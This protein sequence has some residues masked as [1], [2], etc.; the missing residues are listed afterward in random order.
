MLALCNIFEFNYYFVFEDQTLINFSKTNIEFIKQLYTVYDY[1][2]DGN[3]NEVHNIIETLNENTSS[4]LYSIIENKILEFDVHI[5]YQLEET[6]L[7]ITTSFFGIWISENYI[8]YYWQSEEFFGIFSGVISDIIGIIAIIPICSVLIAIRRHSKIIYGLFY[9]ASL[10]ELVIMIKLL[11]N[12]YNIYSYKGKEPDLNLKELTLN[13]WK[14]K[15]E[16]E[17]SLLEIVIIKYEKNKENN[18]AVGVKNI[19]KKEHCVEI[20]FNAISDIMIQTNYPLPIAFKK[21]ISSHSSSPPL[22]E[23]YYYEITILSN[24]NIDGT[25]IAIGFASKTHSTNRLPGC[26]AHSVGFHSDEGR[27]F[28]NEGYT[29]SKYAVKWGEVNDV[30]GCGYYPSTG[31]VFFTM[32]GKN[33][34]IAYAKLFQIW[35]PT[36]GSNGVCSLKV[37]FGQEEFKYIEA[38]G[39]SI[40]GIKS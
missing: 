32:N 3:Q 2:G 20:F 15:L 25:I 37:N 18:A 19:L 22:I 10:L 36:I 9:L 12:Y 34:G 14:F 7:L 11:Y 28:H 26:D 23:Y 40:A 27:I 13:E 16:S 33:L 38:N 4:T 24:Q 8:L 31:K 6:L 39:M 1:Y 35:Y 21:D 5:I 30:I 29:G 17:I